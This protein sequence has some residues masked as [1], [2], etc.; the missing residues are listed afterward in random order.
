MINQKPKFKVGDTVFIHDNFAKIRE[1][2]PILRVIETK[3]YFF[4]QDED[5]GCAEF[6]L[7]ATKNEAV[8]KQIKILKAQVA[9]NEE[10]IQK[11][12][13]S[14]ENLVKLIEKLEKSS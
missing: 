10:E 3:S 2:G 8:G 13:A 1:F 6:R 11:I 9:K 14:Q 5:G 12:K 7:S 4:Y